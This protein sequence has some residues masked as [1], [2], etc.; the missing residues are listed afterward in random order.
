M[1]QEVE[2]DTERSSNS[3]RSSRSYDSNDSIFKYP[4]TFPDDAVL[5]E[6]ATDIHS[7]GQIGNS[8]WSFLAA[9]P[10]FGHE[11]DPTLQNFVKRIGRPS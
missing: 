11:I 2:T 1:T 4:L 8:D 5:D 7:Q 6:N 10:Y 9:K 3:R